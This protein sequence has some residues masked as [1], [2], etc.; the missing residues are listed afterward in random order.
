MV[1]KAGSWA[2]LLGSDGAAEK[3]DRER[4]A[5]A[6]VRFGVFHWRAGRYPAQEAL[7]TYKSRSAAENY[8][9]KANRADPTLNLVVRE[10]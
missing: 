9:D 7:K 5:R 1:R 6:A 10:I 4:S 8:A 3:A 2:W